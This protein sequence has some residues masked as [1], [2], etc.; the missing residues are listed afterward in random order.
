MKRVLLLT[1]LFLAP[2][3]F[4]GC[5]LSSSGGEEV[6]KSRDDV[7]SNYN[8]TELMMELQA[9]KTNGTITPDEQEE[10]GEIYAELIAEADNDPPFGLG[11]GKGKGPPFPPGG[12][13]KGPPFR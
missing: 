3:A 6:K 12:K 2:M 11:K 4:T 7:K 9:R 8:R 13:G 5:G 1:F 10:L